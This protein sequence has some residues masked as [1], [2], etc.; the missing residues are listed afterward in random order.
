MT[1]ALFGALAASA[2]DRRGALVV[3]ISSNA[4]ISAYPGW[5][6]YGASKAGLR[7]LT[8]IWDEEAR[9][10][11]VRFLSVDPGDMDTPLH[12]VAIP[13]ADPSILRRP[14]DSAVEIIEKMLGVLSS[15]TAI[16]VGAQ[17]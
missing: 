7:H 16:K 5:G 1:K 3:N 12:A 14:E 4:A 8:A 15:A 9:D 2:R 17:P 13:N 11:G 6:A 10:D